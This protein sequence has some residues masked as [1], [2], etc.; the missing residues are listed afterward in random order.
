M[1][2]SNEE[3]STA[4]FEILQLPLS[5]GRNRWERQAIGIVQRLAG[6]HVASL[7]SFWVHSGEHHTKAQGHRDWNMDI[8]TAMVQDFEPSQ[9]I[10]SSECERIFDRM[11][12]SVHEGLSAL[13][14]KLG[15]RREVDIFTR[16]FPRRRRNL[17][18]E[19]NNVITSFDDGLEAIFHG[20]LRAHETSYVMRHMLPMYNTV[21]HSGDGT[22]N[23]ILDSLESRV[24][25]PP[26][27]FD[28]VGDFFLSDMASLLEETNEKLQRAT[29]MC[30]E[31]IRRDLDLLR[32]EN[33]SAP[34]ADGVLEMMFN[35]LD[36]SRLRRVEAQSEFET[37]ISELRGPNN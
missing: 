10:F 2:K 19:I 26:R 36:Q 3:L 31:D 29:D 20:L 34:E 18:Y 6:W 14:A 33:I 4:K 12:N 27:L 17:D 32:G 11:N 16:T 30:C 5:Q 23:R 37:R 35:M 7:S 13:L 1:E 15:E 21:T 24:R 25:G 28:V 22:K 8:L 9:D